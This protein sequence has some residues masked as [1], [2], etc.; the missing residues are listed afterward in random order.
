[1]QNEAMCCPS[2]ISTHFL[3][4]HLALM[5]AYVSLTATSVAPSH[6]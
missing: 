4:K 5:A 3:G 6:I 2:V 1:M